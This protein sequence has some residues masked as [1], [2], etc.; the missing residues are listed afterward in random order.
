MRQYTDIDHMTLGMYEVINRATSP[1]ITDGRITMFKAV[2]EDSESYRCPTCMIKDLTET[3]PTD[4]AGHFRKM[5][6]NGDIAVIPVAASDYDRGILCSGCD[7]DLRDFVITDFE[8]APQPVKYVSMKGIM[9]L[10][11][12]DGDSA[13]LWKTKGL[14][15]GFNE[16]TYRTIYADDDTTGNCRGTEGFSAGKGPAIFQILENS[17]VAVTFHDTSVTAEVIATI[18]DP[19]T[20]YACPFCAADNYIR[21]ESDDVVTYDG[22]GKKV[23]NAKQ[24][25]LHPGAHCTCAECDLRATVKEFTVSNWERVEVTE[26]AKS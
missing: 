8:P 21:V 19:N 14:A 25:T 5:V 9:V 1:I 16:C 17:Q 11:D 4:P 10:C 2:S 15:G 18:S 24:P 6:E 23:T 3:T 22:Y 13:E 12:A 7:K 20:K 26:D